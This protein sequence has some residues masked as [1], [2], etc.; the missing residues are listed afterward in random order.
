MEWTIMSNQ[1]LLEERLLWADLETTGL[2]AHTHD[3]LEI[4]LVVTNGEL[5]VIDQFSSPVQQ[6]PEALEKMDVFVKNMHTVS[7]LID[8][9]KSAPDLFTVENQAIEFVSNYF[10]MKKPPLHG[11]T[12]GF[13]QRFL[14]QHMSRLTNLLHYRVVDVSSFKESLRLYSPEVVLAKAQWSAHRAIDD[15]LVSIEEY[16]NY[17][18]FLK[19]L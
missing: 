18:K 3:I 16:R 12:I 6:S 10:G 11:S 15:I 2:H 13:D 14:L 9:V 19:L 17:L 1:R 5:N 7:G 4:G 8:M